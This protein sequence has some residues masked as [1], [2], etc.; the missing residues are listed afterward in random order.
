MR[1]RG[2]GIVAL[3][4]TMAG[5]MGV[6]LANQPMIAD[7]SEVTY[8]ASQAGVQV[9]GNFNR[10]DAQVNLDPKHPE[11]SSVSFSVDTASVAFP[12]SDVQ[13][14]LARPDWFDT[15]R[16]PKAQFRSSSLRGLGAGRYEIAGTLTI[17]S[18]VHDVRFPVDLK[19]SGATTFAVGALSIKRLDYGIGEGEWSDTSLVDDE[20]QIKFKIALSGLPTP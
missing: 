20:V 16:F 15:S 17:K 4:L 6:G 11:S 14:E 13:N 1:V 12:S 19:R 2:A 10:F 5:A 7:Q 9:E 3:V 8:V 18:H